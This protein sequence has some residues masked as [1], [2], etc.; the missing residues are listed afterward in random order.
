MCVSHCCLSCGFKDKTFRKF[1]DRGVRHP[2]EHT[3]AADLLRR[4]PSSE[5]VAAASTFEGDEEF[6]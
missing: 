5:Q 6:R 3:D 4:A 2:G 1:L